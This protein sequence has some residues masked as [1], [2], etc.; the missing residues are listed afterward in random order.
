MQDDDKQGLLNY[1][2]DNANLA[3]H[4]MSQERNLYFFVIIA[5]HSLLFYNP[6]HHSHPFMLI[7]TINI[8]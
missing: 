2:I 7:F 4:N 5:I 6:L 8:S 1:Q 3:C